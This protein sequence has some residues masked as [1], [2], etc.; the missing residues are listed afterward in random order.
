VE[1]HGGAVKVCQEVTS[2][3]TAEDGHV[4]GVRAVD[5]SGVEP[6]EVVYHAPIVISNAGAHITYK[7]LLPT[8]GEIG[9]RTA[10]LRGLID[11]L[12]GGP[13]A[14]TLYLRLEKPVS[15]IGV[16]GENYWINTTFDHNDLNVQ[17]AAVLAGKPQHAYMSFP[18]AKSGDARFHTAEILAIVN[19]DAFA[20]WRATEHG[21]RGSDYLDLKDRISQGLLDLAETAT[22]GLKAL[23]RYAELSTPLSVEDYTSHPL[24]AIYGVKGT[25]ERFRSTELSSTRPYR[26]SISAE[27]TH[28]ISA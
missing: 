22:P 23:V 8:D 10:A 5:L 13:S 3:L 7:R 17:T 15:T 9:R 1:A 16:K 19:G 27:A 12:D 14:V 21:M 11:R 20:A 2:I 26:G 18:S 25:P 4:T 28:R 24:G 6:T